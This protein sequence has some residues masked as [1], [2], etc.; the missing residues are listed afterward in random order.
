M[1]YLDDVSE[2]TIELC[3]SAKFENSKGTTALLTQSEK[4]YTRHEKPE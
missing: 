4:N 1:A 2:I 3:L